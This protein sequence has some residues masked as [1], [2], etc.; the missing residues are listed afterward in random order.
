MSQ[1]G[2]IFLKILISEFS[3]FFWIFPELILIFTNFNSF[4]K[5]QKGGL[6][7]CTNC[8][9]TCRGMGHVAEP[10]EPRGRLHGA[11]VARTR[12]RATWVHTN[13]W[14]APTW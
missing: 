9:L 14:L 1:K 6:I 8:G 4:K 12:G 11:D 5:W 7:S 10:C 3:G 13:A 2:V